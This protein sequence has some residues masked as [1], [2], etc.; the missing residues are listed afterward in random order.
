MRI[1][2]EVIRG[3]ETEN[4]KSIPER[5]HNDHPRRQS[6]KEC[7]QHWIWHQ[8]WPWHPPKPNT[9]HKSTEKTHSPHIPL[10]ISRDPRRR[11]SGE[12]STSYR[13]PL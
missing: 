6:V 13:P 8:R 5:T 7:C 9:K 1:C 12:A 10:H 3:G 11:H 4:T 2:H